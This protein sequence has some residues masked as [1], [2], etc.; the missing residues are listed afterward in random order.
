MRSRHQLSRAG[1]I[2]CCFV[3]KEE[4]MKR[5]TKKP[6]RYGKS[7]KLPI[8]IRPDDDD[9]ILSFR[10]WCQLNRLGERTGNQGAGRHPAQR[11]TH[12][13]LPAR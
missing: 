11:Q 4:T 3:L 2:R 8:L 6:R 12:R 13:H 5:R 7:R 9:A 10:E 1:G